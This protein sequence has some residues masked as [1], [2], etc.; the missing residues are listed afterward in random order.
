MSFSDGWGPVLLKKRA[1]TIREHLTKMDLKALVVTEGMNTAYVTGILPGTTFYPNWER[2]G[3]TVIPLDGEPFTIQNELIGYGIRLA[4]ERK[5]AWI[6]DVRLWQEHPRLTNRL[7]IRRELGLMLSEGLKERGITKGQVGV[8]AASLVLHNL[9]APYLPNVECVN[10]SSILREMRMVKCEE[11]L[12][13]IRKAGELSDWAQ[14]KYQ[15]SAS[16]GK[17]I[18]ALDAEIAH[19]LAIETTEKYP[20]YHIGVSSHTIGF[21]PYSWAGGPGGYKGTKIERGHTLN[22]A[23]SV[24]LNGY[25]VENERTM[26][27]GQPSEKQR[28]IFNVATE[29]QKKGVSKCVEGN[30]VSDIDAA[31]QEVIEKAGYGE[32]ITHRAGHGIGL[33]GHEH[34]DDMAYDHMKMKEGMVTSVEPAIYIYLDSGYR[35]SDTVIIGKREPEPVTKYSKELENLIIAV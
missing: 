9:I 26:V 33:G 28:K 32:Y 12:R 31:S 30:R 7:H 14:K 29:A 25:G 22:N 23:I 13:L 16:V 2:P 19:V 8:D 20:E 1:D 17:R 34:W 24:R 27:V 5:R 35:H 3:A 6:T 15:E 18:Y 10:A 21:G 4:L 11:E